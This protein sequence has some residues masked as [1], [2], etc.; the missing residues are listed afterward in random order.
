[1][2][3]KIINSGSVGN[4][5]VLENDTCALIIECGVRFDFIKQAINFNLS[6]VAGVLISHEHGDHCKSAKEVAAAGINIYCS[7][8]TAEA[9]NVAPHRVKAIEANSKWLIGEFSVIPFDV[10]HDA[11]QPFGFL[12]NHP[13]CGTVLFITDTYYVEHT[14]KGVNNII[15]E[16][17]YCQKIVDKRL[18]ENNIHVALR[19]RVLESH[20]SIDT[21]L[22]LLA[23]NDLTSVNNIVLIHLSDGNSNS[24]DFKRRVQ[25]QTGKTV[26]VAGKNMEIDFNKAPF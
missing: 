4:C 20:M 26:T 10:K 14:F 2:R 15:I 25:E 22:A 5:Y 21:C 11:A 9:M 12:I 17:N 6:K 7:K 23:V 19:N 1:M 24:A 18:A 3:L 16:A 8:G 13:E